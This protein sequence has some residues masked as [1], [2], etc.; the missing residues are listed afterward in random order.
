MKKII[1]IVVMVL[2]TLSFASC[3]GGGGG[4]GSASG[5]S[6]KTLSQI[7]SATSPMA[8]SAASINLRSLL[9]PKAATT[10]MTL[11]GT[12]SSDFN[13][14]SSRAACEMFNVLAGSF[15]AAN[16]AEMIRC[17]IENMESSF[18][19]ATGTSDDF[20]LYDGQFHVFDI[21]ISGQ[22][23][24]P[25][26]IMMKVDKNE[27]DEITAIE[28]FTC[29]GTAPNMEQVDYVDFSISDSEISMTSKAA[30]GDAE[31][32]GSN[33]ISV[34][35]TLN[36]DLA[37]TNRT[38]NVASSGSEIASGNQN[39]SVGT[40]TQTPGSGTYSGFQANDWTDGDNS[41]SH[42]KAVYGVFDVLNDT[43]EDLLAVAIG[44]GV[45]KGN[46][47]DSWGDGEDESWSETGVML[48]WTGDDTLPVEPPTGSAHYAAAYAGTVPDVSVPTIAFGEGETWDCSDEIDGTVSGDGSFLEPL[49]EPLDHDWVNCYQVIDQD[50]PVIFGGPCADVEEGP[51]SYVV[52]RDAMLLIDEFEL[53][54]IECIAQYAHDNGDEDCI[55]ASSFVAAEDSCDYDVSGD[56]SPDN[57]TLTMVSKEIELEVGENNVAY[58]IYFSNPEG[59]EVSTLISLANVVSTDDIGVYPYSG[60]EE[61]ADNAAICSKQV[62]YNDSAHNCT[63]FNATTDTEYYTEIFGVDTAGSETAYLVIG[64]QCDCVAE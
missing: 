44:D 22:E 24:G 8:S 10:G 12:A 43:G 49:C 29:K 55:T 9:S 3:G 19:A 23:H 61:P 38:I 1:G 53:A 26:K 56:G 45:I 31:W 52:F 42:S 47:F 59:G 25:S 60:G 36:G 37:F 40:L 18:V 7:P 16:Q 62:T 5:P 34:Q 20:D 13:G 41:G 33:S 17:Y 64:N 2:V 51:W 11:G 15:K 14:N 6:I 46:F 27:S 50:W 28:M 63:Y 30:G 57:L 48:A 39:Y 21:S 54:D 35:G 4:G 32:A 58:T